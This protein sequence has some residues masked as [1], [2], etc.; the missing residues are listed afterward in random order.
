MYTGKSR[1]EGGNFDL[2]NCLEPPTQLLISEAKAQ[3]SD[4]LLLLILF[5]VY[6]SAETPASEASVATAAACCSSRLKLF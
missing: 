5:S 4:L 6:L 1:I 3:T 2:S